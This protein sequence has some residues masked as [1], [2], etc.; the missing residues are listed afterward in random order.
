MM[1]S[2]AFALVVLTATGL[3][4]QNSVKSPADP[5]PS[6]TRI[7]GLSLTLSSDGK[8]D[9]RQARIV[10]LY[11]PKGEAVSSFFPAGPFT[12]KWEGEIESPLRSSYTLSLQLLGEAKV[13][14]NDKP[15][16]EA[17]GEGAGTGNNTEFQTRLNKGPNKVVVEFTSDNKSDAMI[18]LNWSSKS[19]PT[20][21]ISP[22]VWQHTP[23]TPELTSLRIHQGRALFSQS[24]CIQCHDGASLAPTDGSGMPELM[25]TGPDLIDAGARFRPEW[26][27]AWVENP[28]AVRADARMPH[29]GLSKEQSA[30]VAAYLATLGKAPEASDKDKP[31]AEKAATGGALFASVGCIACHTTPDFTAEDTHG[32]TALSQTKAKFYPAALREFL[33]TPT[34]HNPWTR[35]PNFRLTDDELDSLSHYLLSKSTREFPSAKGDAAKGKEIFANVGCANCHAVTDVKSALKAKS[36]Q[37]TLKGEWQTGCVA[38]DVAARG[39]AP[40]FHFTPEQRDSLVAFAATGFDALKRDNPIGFAERQIR[41][42]NCVA[43][44]GRD[45]VQST[46]SQIEA[47]MLPLTSAIPAPKDE[48]HSETGTLPPTWVPE[49]TWLGEKLQPTWMGSFI[50]GVAPY[51]P[52]PWLKGR[53]PGFGGPGMGIANGLAFQH[54]FSLDGQ[55]ATPIDPEKV[56]NGEKLVG[57]NGG[58]NCTTCHGVKDKAATAVFEAPGINLGYSSERLRPSFFHRWLSAP[59]RIDSST[60]MPKFSDDGKTTALTDV[61]EGKAP[62]QFE[63]MWQYL[64]SLNAR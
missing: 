64:R 25:S 62:E 40:D 5:A 45:G 34:L 56:K 12:A 22:T 3:V 54:G 43:C 47:E 42:M 60:K 15:A 20:E 50:V 51:K 33:Q 27:A 18:R 48:H 30:D 55:D 31:V 53:M 16:M 32:R 1:R 29:L 44:H 41:N 63:A 10:A 26:V 9:I 17:K 14:I 52:R 6:D 2:L 8:T 46:W 21:P 39:K 28:K 37:E 61:Y 49:L 7:Q 4:A 57:Q 59:L 35:M 13:T 11:V 58:F 24:L 38:P 36:L 23:T 19:F